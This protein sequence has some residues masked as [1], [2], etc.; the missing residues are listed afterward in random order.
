MSRTTER[1]IDDDPAGADAVE[2]AGETTAADSVP[3]P[4]DD[5]PV[6]EGTRVNVGGEGE[7][8]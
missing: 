3:T 8:G 5:R 6:G 2:E 7:A 1:Q 4:A